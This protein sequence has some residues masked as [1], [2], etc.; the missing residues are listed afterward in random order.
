MG[1]EEES[2]DIRR[3][4]IARGARHLHVSDDVK[5]YL[6]TLDPEATYVFQTILS[7]GGSGTPVGLFR[8]VAHLGDVQTWVAKAVGWQQGGAT[9][10][11]LDAKL[12][13][14]TARHWRPLYAGDKSVPKGVG[15]GT[16]PQSMT[17]AQRRN[18][19]RK[20]QRAIDSERRY[21]EILIGNDQEAA[22][23]YWRRVEA[24]RKGA[25]KAAKRK[26]KA[27]K[28]VKRRR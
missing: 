10:E 9:I 25:D 19:A 3:G 22:T 20:V 4:V 11:S 5:A 16:N 6:A 8:R 17:P 18:N 26:R 15:L 21:N 14:F 12:A 27:T 2:R 1:L 24:A 28:S 13:G 23:Q 7:G